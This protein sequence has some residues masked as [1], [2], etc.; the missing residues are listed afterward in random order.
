MGYLLVY[1]SSSYEFNSIIIRP[2]F[3]FI[4]ELEV[5]DMSSDTCE[6]H[7]TLLWIVVE[8]EVEWEMVDWIEL[9]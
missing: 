3:V 1:F 5:H 7:F 8:I 4:F 2:L 6:E 9:G